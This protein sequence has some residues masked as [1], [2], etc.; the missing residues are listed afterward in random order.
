[1]FNSVFW[2]ELRWKHESTK[3]KN[4]KDIS[5]STNTKKWL[6]KL[7]N[8]RI[9]ATKTKVEDILDNIIWD[10]EFSIEEL[11]NKRNKKLKITYIFY[12]FGVIENENEDELKKFLNKL[13]QE[14]FWNDR[15]ANIINA[16]IK[17]F[18]EGINIKVDPKE[19]Y[20]WSK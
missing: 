7:N 3:Q 14:W 6:W 15:K 2:W 10:K 13:K 5:K 17:H 20:D 16:L 9:E 11:E 4:R 18:I 12:I 1:M 8:E 19:A